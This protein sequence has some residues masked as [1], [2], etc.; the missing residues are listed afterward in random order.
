M[1]MIGG[2]IVKATAFAIVIAPMRSF[3]FNFI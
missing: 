2:A 3:D 1:A